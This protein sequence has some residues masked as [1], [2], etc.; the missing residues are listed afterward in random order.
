MFGV[1][2]ESGLIAAAGLAGQVTIPAPAITA[3]TEKAC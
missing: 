1:E 2:R 3:S